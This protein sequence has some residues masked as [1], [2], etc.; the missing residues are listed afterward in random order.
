MDYNECCRSCLQPISINYINLLTDFKIRNLF[1]D[2]TRLKV[3]IKK[4]F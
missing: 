4:K 3:K 1:E 2:C